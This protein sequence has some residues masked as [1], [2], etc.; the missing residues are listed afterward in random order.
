MLSAAILGAGFMGAT[1]AAGWKA[2][3]GRARVCWVS[4]RSS[5]KAARTAAVVGA[6]P[7]TDLWA[8]IGDPEVQAVD[9]CLPTLLHREA[10]ER[11]FAAR[12]HVLLEKPIAL[13]IGDADAILAA[14]DRSGC[15]LLVALVL[16]FFPEYKEIERRV[17]GRSM[18]RPL[19]VST[20]RLSPPADWNDWIRDPVQSGGPAVDLLIHDFDQ[21]NWLL[22]RPRRVF[23]R[24]IAS[25]GGIPGH[26]VSVVEYD[27][28]EAAAE[29]SM[30]M[31]RS[32]PFSAGIRV[33][34]EDGVLEHGF[35]AGP[36]EGGGNIGG[37]ISRFLRIYPAAGDA[38]P[39][40]I[41]EEDPWAAE[42][43][44]FVGCIE[45]G[46]SA[47]RGTGEQAR[48][49]LRVSLAANRSLERGK[50]EAV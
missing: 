10:C 21:M 36:A 19:E 31:P 46:R 40:P 4:S 49:A 45:T 14:R 5:E 50:P 34:C 18:G 8:P 7:T 37:D 33:L 32:Y 41:Q 48:E 26:L 13:S 24:S 43:A 12:K 35:R 29:G 47:T 42:I 23:A 6:R 15:V 9:V 39:V 11:A 1:H 16:R 27:D 3:G 22:G 17:A 44:Y 2:L 25:Q 20:Y 30:M 28:A 38:A